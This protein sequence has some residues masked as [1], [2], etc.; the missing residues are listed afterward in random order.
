MKASAKP[1]FVSSPAEFRAWLHEHH[2]TATEVWAGF[3]KK[4]T[5]KPGMT[6]PES[7]DQALCYG[8][9]DGIRKSIDA[10]RYMIRFTPRRKGS[11]WS[12]VN[13][14]RVAELEKAKLMHAAGRAAF[15]RRH[16]E[17]SR[18]Y[19]YERETAELPPEYVKRFRANRKAWTFFEAQPPS[20]RKVVA[21]WIASAK[22]P[23][24]REKRLARLIAESA[25]GRRVV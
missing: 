2:D 10:E 5:G 14:K 24:T 12:A 7:V 11:V 9:I 23:E 20:Y 25:A 3:W 19:S 18:Q 21:F 4:A 8:W 15:A 6:W 1:I 17:K 22:R 13:I 16:E